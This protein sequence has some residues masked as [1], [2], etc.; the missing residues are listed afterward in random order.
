MSNYLA[1]HGRPT[2]A[3][4]MFSADELLNQGSSLVQY[5]GYDYLGNKPTKKLTVDDFLLD[6][7][8]RYI[9]P[10]EPIYIAGYIQDQFDF[11]GI[12]FRLG[13]RIDRYDANEPVLKDPYSLLPTFTAGDING[14]YFGAD[15]YIKPGN[16][17]DGYIPYV[18]DPLNP[19]AAPIGYRDPVTNNWYD[20]TG[21]QVTDVTYLANLNGGN[22]TPYLNAAGL[23]KTDLSKPIAASFRQY[24]PQTNYSPRILFSFPISDVAVFYANYDILSQRPKTNNLF[25][26]DDY[27][28][29][30]ERSTG[31]IDNPN[32][33]PETRINYQVG[34]KQ[35]IGKT[36]VITLEANYSEMK[37]EIQLRRINFA[38]P[39]T[40]YT[41]YDN[42]DFGTVKGINIIYD[43]RRVNSAGVAFKA[44]YGLQFANGTG[45][46]SGSQGAL[47]EAGQPNLRTPLPLDYDVRHRLN[48]TLDYRFGVGAEYE[49]PTTDR[50]GG[51]NVLLDNIYRGLFENGGFFILGSASSGMPYSRQS[52]V[53]TDV[54]LGVAQ[55]TTLLG[56]PND[57]RL[58]W[59]YHVDLTYDKDILIRSKKN[60][61]NSGFRGSE[62]YLNVR[63]TV[64]NIFNIQNI[65]SVYRYTGRPDDDGYLASAEGQKELN[66][67]ADL[68]ARQAFQDQYNVRLLAP[69]NYGSPRIV[70]LGLSYSF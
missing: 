31:V 26:I 7:V 24:T 19:T 29:L 11:Y 30:K 1:A 34:F 67:I 62:H 2:G 37:D 68:S 47:I 3:L 50:Q 44:N 45:S 5:Y 20:A 25:T 61:E 55:R 10:F 21:K 9:A 13:L 58:P 28:F 6:S 41:T 16:I 42:I 17:G 38:Y 27:Y 40:S 56:E 14:K 60:M 51:L 35:T 4:N 53:T 65:V 52:N 33:K 57:T 43:Y 48:A 22:L 12:N 39:V 66:N 64:Q 15:K 63:I 23:S 59:N 36:S 69:G 8:H 70:R 49:G 32:L 54:E 18:N 46:N